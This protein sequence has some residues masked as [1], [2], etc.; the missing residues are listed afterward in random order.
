[1]NGIQWI[2]VIL[3]IGMSASRAD[4]IQDAY[5]RLLS[6]ESSQVESVYHVKPGEGMFR[7]H[8]KQQQQPKVRVSGKGNP[9]VLKMG[10][11]Y[12]LSTEGNKGASWWFADFSPVR[13]VKGPPTKAYEFKCTFEIP[14]DFSQRKGGPARF[15]LG[16]SPSGYWYLYIQPSGKLEVGYKDKNGY[17]DKNE[18]F[19]SARIKH[20]K[21]QRIRFVWFNDGKFYFELDHYKKFSGHN[22]ANGGNMPCYGLSNRINYNQTVLIYEVVIRQVTGNEGSPKLVDRSTP[23]SSD[24]EN[25]FPVKRNGKLGFIDKT[26]RVVIQPQW[27]SD[28]SWFRDGLAI[29]EIDGKCGFIDKTGKVVIQPRWD[30]A[31]SFSEGLACVEIDGKYGCIDKKGEIVIQ[32]EWDNICIVRGGFAEIERNGKYGFIDKVGKVVSKPQWDKVDDFSD[33]LAVVKQGEKY[34]Y[35]NEVGRV[36]SKPQWDKAY[37]CVDGLA[38]VEKGGKCGY[39]NKTGKVVIKLQ[40]DGAA[41]FSNGLAIV[42]KDGKWG[43]IDKRGIVVIPL[44]WEGIGK[45]S[46]GFIVKRDRKAG[47]IDKN[48]K[49][50]IPP[51]YDRIT[52]FSDGIACVEKNGKWGRVDKTGKVVSELQ[53]DSPSRYSGGLAIVRKAGKSFYINKARKLIKWADTGEV[54]T[55]QDGE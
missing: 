15:L 54:I 33:G 51:Q 18:V 22:K 29:V 21:K 27:D 14:Q 13:V 47:F 45:F 41:P 12:H 4:E 55:W 34:G 8:G 20:G 3:M 37:R 25:L 17:H 31:M 30:W 36:V 39:I 10:G 6:A 50:L 35:I 5:R 52:Q 49:I 1:M 48:G 9:E 44:Q 53:W 38:I 46:D 43:C 40:W 32:P 24:N 2:W 28:R 23:A 16:N 11:F 19:K 7:I 26:G 42:V